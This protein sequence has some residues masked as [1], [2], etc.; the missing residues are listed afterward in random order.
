[1]KRLVLLR[2]AKSSWA[3]PGQDD[4]ARPLNPRGQRAALLLGTWLRQ[5]PWSLDVILSSTAERTQQTVAGLELRQPPVLDK[6]LY[7]ASPTTLWQRV[8]QTSE[9]SVLLVAHNPGI[10]AL[11][12]QLVAAPPKHSRFFDYPTGALT[13]VAFD[14]DDWHACVPGQGIATDFVIPADLG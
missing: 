8:Q 2:H 4:H 3:T 6:S 12:E 1:M 5:K 10:A 9:A 7:L 14:A 11:A 13:V